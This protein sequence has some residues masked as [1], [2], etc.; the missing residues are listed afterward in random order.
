MQ[1]DGDMNTEVNKRTP[2]GW[3][4]WRKMSGVL[5]DKKVP[6]HVKVK[7]HKTIVQPVMPYGMETLQMTNSHVKKR[8]VTE[9]KRF[10]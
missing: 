6:P 5:C 4:N 1:R 9:M 3:N 2:C 7:I 8:E 10:R